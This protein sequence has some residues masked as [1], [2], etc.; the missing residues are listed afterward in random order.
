MLVVVVAIFATLW[1]PY[2][3]L[4]VYNSLLAMFGQQ[5]FKDL[6]YLL[7]AK[8]CIFINSAIN[9]ILY[10]ALSVKFRRSFKKM[11]SCG[12]S[13]A[14]NQWHLTLLNSEGVR[15]LGRSP[16]SG[17]AHRAVAHSSTRPL[18][19]PTGTQVLDTALSAHA[20][21]LTPGN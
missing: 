12:S 6:W 16:S 15:R 13:R 1:L 14:G 8:T 5:P 10:N 7:F 4:L 19:P 17:P 21:P 20:S 11:L 3:T 18:Y 9:P 2:R